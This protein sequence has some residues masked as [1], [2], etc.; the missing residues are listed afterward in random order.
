[1][2]RYVALLRGIN[3]GGKNI[4]K[5]VDLRACFEEEGFEDVATYIQSGNV[6]FEAPRTSMKALTD[7]VANMLDDRYGLDSVVIRSATQMKKVVDTAPKGFG[8]K[9]DDYRYD[10]IFLKPELKAAAAL[11]AIPRREGVDQAW[12]GTGVLYFSRLIAQASKSKLSKLASMA[13]Y[14]Q[15]TVRNWRTTNKLLT[16]LEG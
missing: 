2:G 12:S 9:P 7:R 13:I 16:M 10:V 14:K 4:I 6:V 1:M 5:M 3:V 15:V 11:A 8:T